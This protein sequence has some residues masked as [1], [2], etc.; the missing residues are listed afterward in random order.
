MHSKANASL[1]TPQ[2][3]IHIH[4]L[5]ISKPVLSSW[6]FSCPLLLPFANSQAVADYNLLPT[7]FIMRFLP[8]PLLFS[9]AIL[10]YSSLADCPGHVQSASFSSF[11]LCW[12]LLDVFGYSFSLIHNKKLSP[13]HGVVILIVLLLCPVY[14]L[15]LL[16]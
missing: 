1:Q 6:P 14:S 16:F 4:L 2:T 11:S 9:L 12:T 8:L 10:C 7:L 13:D 5:C 3:P 15:D